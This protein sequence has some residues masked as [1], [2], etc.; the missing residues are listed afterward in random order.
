MRPAQ[1]PGCKIEEGV[2]SQGHSQASFS[3]VIFAPHLHR[4]RPGSEAGRGKGEEEEK[5]YP[6][7]RAQPRICSKL[8]LERYYACLSLPKA[9]SPAQRPV[10]S[11]VE[12]ARAGTSEDARRLRRVHLAQCFCFTSQSLWVRVAPGEAKNRESG[13]AASLNI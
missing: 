2:H 5:F 13:E 9:P 10:I 12:R 6:S 7:Q 8:E 3:F 1:I 4:S 11:K